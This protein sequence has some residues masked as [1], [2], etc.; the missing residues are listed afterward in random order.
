MKKLSIE[1]RTYDLPC[2][3]QMLK[4][5][6]PPGLSCSFAEL[7]RRTRFLR[8]ATALPRY[9]LNSTF[10][11][12]H[13]TDHNQKPYRYVLRLPRMNR[14]DFQPKDSF[15]RNTVTRVRKSM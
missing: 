14:H 3:N 10:Q 9:L 4:T 15:H 11:I 6:R 5:S 13:T 2:A 12:N 7:D 8:I 1:I